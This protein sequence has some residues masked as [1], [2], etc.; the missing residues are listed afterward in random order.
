M[1]SRRLSVIWAAASV[2]WLSIA[3]AGAQSVAPS[4]TPSPAANSAAQPSTSQVPSAPN[5]QNSPATRLPDVAIT[6]TRITQ[7]LDSIGTT[8]TIVHDQQIQDQKIQQVSDALREVPGV[9]VTQSGGPGTITDVSIRGAT[10]SQVLVLLDG[11][12]VNS[13]TAGSFDFANLT[14]DNT[15]R[16]EVLRG[17]GGSLY[18]SSAIGGVINL[19]SQEGSGPPKFTLLSDG[20]NWETQRQVAT[21][22]GAYGDLGYSGSISYYS[23]NGFQSVN[24]AYDNLSGAGRLD[25]H[26]NENTTLRGFAR[27]T[28]AQVGLPEYSNFYPG[29]PLDP[30]AN[31]RYDFMLFK[32]EVDSHPTDKL[33]IHYF[34]SFVRDETRDNKTPAPLTYYFNADDIPEEIWGQNGEAVYTW[35][36]GWISLAGFDFK[37][38]WA[39]VVSNS[40]SYAPPPCPKG[41]LRAE[42][43]APSN[44]VF[45]ATQQ[46]YAGYL[47]Q[48]GSLL[49][50]HLLL[51]GGFRVDGNSQFG[52]EVSPS[53][54]VA[55][56]LTRYGINL[57]GNYA[58]GF[59][60]PTFDDLY[61]P[62]FGNPNLKPTISSEYDGSIEKHFGELSS[63]TVTYF[64]RR[65]HNLIVAAP[66]GT[67]GAVLAENIGRDDTQGVELVPAIYPFKGFSLSGN[68]TVLDSTHDPHT[69]TLQ[70][71]RVPKHAAA[72]VAQYKS[73]SLLRAGD[74]FTAALFY[75]F[76][77]DF[78][79][80]QTQPPFGYEN[81]GGYQLFNLTLSY[82]L[83]SGF[84]PRLTSE[85]AFVRIQ[86]LFDRNYSQAFGYPA[87]PINFEAGLKIG[88]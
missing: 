43:P 57:R 51:T 19:I 28:S 11:V 84:A 42:C 54:A 45:S 88:L 9:E 63:F 12:E 44:S 70:P 17:A 29:A 23:T 6:A 49:H 72:G 39:R 10:S 15:D 64:S 52:E 18:G 37:N 13:N 47:Q 58:E 62:D 68:F 83:G 81:H 67:S 25:W 8:I 73:A 71:V 7:P 31:Q 38:L 61:F 65:I 78:N 14:T 46:Q 36:P 40:I 87:P 55:V 26:L 59:E 48:Q 77:G 33:A 60:A 76:V 74:Q 22:N 50:D 3:A 4:P 82:D 86:N 16:L 56:P 35:L 27:Y 79:D 24:S 85:E 1:R 21:A 5:T 32:G 34:G 69:P 66:T 53:W 75:Q 80:I 41:A 30:S 2:Y 20:G